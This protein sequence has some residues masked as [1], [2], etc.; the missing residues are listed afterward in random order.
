MMKEVLV[1]GCF[2]IMG[3]ISIGTFTLFN[4]LTWT[5]A[6]PPFHSPPGQRP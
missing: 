6:N 4:S 1:G 3:R 5:L 2:L